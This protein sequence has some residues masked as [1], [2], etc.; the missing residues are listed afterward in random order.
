MDGALIVVPV[1]R[2]YSSR[3]LRAGSE[4]TEF[5]TARSIGIDTDKRPG[6]RNSIG[7]Q[8]TLWLANPSSE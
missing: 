8:S 6:S 4:V 3:G 5:G 2:H 1:H 7:Q